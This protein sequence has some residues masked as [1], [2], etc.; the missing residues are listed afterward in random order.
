MPTYENS[1]GGQPI[2]GNHLQIIGICRFSYPA[3][4]GFQVDHDSIQD[5]VRFLYDPARM[6]ERFRLFECFTL[7]SLRAQTDPRFTLVIVI[8]DNLPAPWRGR[9]ADLTR[10]MPQV[11]IDERPP[12][13]H[14]PVMKRIINRART[15]MDQ[16]CVQF[17]MDDDDA[18]AVDFVEKIRLT[19]DECSDMIARNRHVAID[20]NQGMIAA[21]GPDGI[22]AA[23]LTE[24]MITAGLA[25]TVPPRIHNT[26]LNFSHKRMWK[27]MAVVAQPGQDMFLRG[28]SEFNDSR[29]G[30]NVRRFDLAPLTADQEAHIKRRFDV[31]ADQV[32]AAFRRA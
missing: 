18:V 13:R 29:Q 11:V 32:R 4:G 9:L 16:H 1:T 15:D 22:A 25:I 20:F 7:P 26:V 8:G 28:H 21:P 24:G 19:V 30:D 27:G 12:A 10:D 3:I 31:S 5:R 6:E 2:D 23:P 14:R 17:R